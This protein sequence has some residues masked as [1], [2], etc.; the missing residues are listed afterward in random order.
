MQSGAADP[1]RFVLAGPRVANSS[2][3]G[4]WRSALSARVCGL[5]IDM[6]TSDGGCVIYKIAEVATVRSS[7]S[8]FLGLA[9]GMCAKAGG[10]VIGK[11]SDAVSVSSSLSQ[12]FGLAIGMCVKV[13]GCVIDK[14]SEVATAYSSLSQLL[15]LAIGMCAKVGGCVIDLI[16]E[17][18]TSVCLNSLASL[19]AFAR[20]SSAVLLTK[21]P[22]WLR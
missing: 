15:G 14:V 3:P 21:S 4:S 2:E 8:Q 16:S 9:I 10:G 1:G 6:C 22:K 5:A 17:V 18:V 19:P 20:R 7:L 11:I 12:F 13:G